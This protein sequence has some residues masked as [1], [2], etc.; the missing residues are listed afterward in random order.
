MESG[1]MVRKTQRI[2]KRKFFEK[3][4]SGRPA[5]MLQLL[6]SK[7]HKNKESELSPYPCHL[8]PQC[9]ERFSQLT[10]SLTGK[11]EPAVRPCLRS[12]MV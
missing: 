6:E 12:S 2:L 7:Q 3:K 5:E 10:I 9:P 4:K 1:G 8:C 11:H